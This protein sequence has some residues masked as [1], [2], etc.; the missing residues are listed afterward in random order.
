MYTKGFPGVSD[1]EESACNAG[2]LGMIPVLGGSP[3][4]RNGKPLQYSYLENPMDREPGELQSMGLQRVRHNW[5][6]NIHTHKF[7]KAWFKENFQN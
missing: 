6:T 4:E 1:G 2:D 7:K 5:A 3:G